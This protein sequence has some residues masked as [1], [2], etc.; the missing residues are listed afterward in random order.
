L[1]E[2]QQEKERESWE[3]DGV[4]AKRSLKRA[5]DTQRDLA[6][7]IRTT[8][9]EAIG[10]VSSHSRQNLLRRRKARTS[11]NLEPVNGDV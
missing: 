5:Q 9:N 2:R 11:E 1:K 6:N 3:N 7:R 4:I 8:L 10:K